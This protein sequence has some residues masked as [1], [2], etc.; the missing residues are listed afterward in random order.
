MLSS[1]GGEEKEHFPFAFL[2]LVLSFALVLFIEKIATDHHHGPSDEEKK[3]RKTI[4]QTINRDYSEHYHDQGEGNEDHHH[5][6]H[7]KNAVH[8]S[9]LIENPDDGNLTN[10]ML[11]KRNE[12]DED[13]EDFKNVMRVPNK[14]AKK[15]SFIQDLKKSVAMDRIYFL[16][17]S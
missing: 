17:F 7:Q 5:H 16:F 2:T 11:G 3:I 9:N 15:M 10:P 13:E 1:D 12:D 4:L 6:H 8:A 14:I